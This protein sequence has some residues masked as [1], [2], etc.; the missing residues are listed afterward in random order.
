MFAGRG[1][2][3]QPPAWHRAAANTRD[4]TAA[5]F[6]GQMVKPQQMIIFWITFWITRSKAAVLLK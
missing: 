5:G 1:Y 6:S 2:L 3:F 4:R